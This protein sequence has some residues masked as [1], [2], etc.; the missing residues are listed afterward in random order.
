MTRD[1]LTLA[2]CTSITFNNRVSIIHNHPTL[3]T[4]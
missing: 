2:F 4:V 1:P 3:D